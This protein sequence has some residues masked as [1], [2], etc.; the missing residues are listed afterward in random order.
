MIYQVRANIYFNDKDEARDFYH[1][2]E[3]AYPKGIDL[4]PDTVAT[5]FSIVQLIENHHDESPNA[6]C[7]CIERLCSYPPPPE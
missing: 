3:V 7:D 6:P 4:N 5:E 2:C 1:D